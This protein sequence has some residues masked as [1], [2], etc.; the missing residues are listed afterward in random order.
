MTGNAVRPV[1]AGTGLLVDI[2]EK[3]YESPQSAAAPGRIVLSGCRF[4]AAAGE[5]VALVG[6]SGCGKTT[7]LNIVA[8][9]DRDY[10]GTVRL[11]R[12]GDGTPAR[13]GVVFQAPRLLPWRTV[14]ENVRLVL[15]ALDRDAPPRVVEEVLRDVG[16]ERAAWDAY[17]GRLSGGMSRRAAVARAFAVAPDLLLMDEPFVSLDDPAA[18]GLRRA[19]LALWRRRPTT[20]LFVTHDLRE[21]LF[22]A[23]RVLLLSDAPGCVLD[24]VAVPAAREA[25][26]AAMLDR[27][28]DDFVARRRELLAAVAA[29]T[30][31]S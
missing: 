1:A 22:L 8:G 9:L 25:R 17:P 29:A 31:A 10:D 21:A 5:F 16:L 18:D 14:R 7:L 3:R 4:A 15:P 6:P 28:R 24:A 11:P 13:L 23:D 30:S 26:D 12:R 2:R 19:L 27:L 20:V